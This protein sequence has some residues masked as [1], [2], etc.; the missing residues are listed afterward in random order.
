MIVDDFN[1]IGVT[2]GTV[3]SG[4]IGSVRRLEYTVFGRPVQRAS[5]LHDHCRH[6]DA[7]VLADDNAVQTLGH[8]VV[9][10]VK[11]PVDGLTCSALTGWR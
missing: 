2:Y 5:L 4:S 3:F 1:S 8:A 7:E 11:P 9:T 10:E 6:V